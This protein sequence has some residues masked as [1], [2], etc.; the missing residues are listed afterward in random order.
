MSNYK[1]TA[2]FSFEGKPY[3]EGESVNVTDEVAIEK[4]LER[5]QIAKGKG[6]EPEAEKVNEAE[7]EQIALSTEKVQ[8]APA[9][10]EVKTANGKSTSKK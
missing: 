8:Q 9:A 1:A 6:V 4:L 5:G 10:K 3:N 2:N 7:K